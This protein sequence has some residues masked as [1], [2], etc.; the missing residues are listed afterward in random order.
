MLKVSDMTLNECATGRAS[1]S[2]K[3]ITV[4]DLFNSG[5]VEFFAREL[6]ED[7]FFP[8]YG[9]T[10]VDFPKVSACLKTQP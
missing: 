8:F 6:P 5:N 3:E 4:S 10:V 2:V 7:S 9:I 1:A